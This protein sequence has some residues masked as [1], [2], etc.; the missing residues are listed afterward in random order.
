[1]NID[2]SNQS[3]SHHSKEYYSLK[4]K[5]ETTYSELDQ[6]IQSNQYNIRWLHDFLPSQSSFTEQFNKHDDDPFRLFHNERFYLNKEPINSIP[7]TNC[8][9]VILLCEKLTYL[10]EVL[11][12]LSHQSTYSHYH[13]FLSL[14]CDS[15]HDS[16]YIKSRKSYLLDAYK[17]SIKTLFNKRDSSCS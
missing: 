3:K 8:A 17:I 2:F 5:T 1:M 10:D 9:I 12:T 16:V 4:H 13:L 11:D 7:L 15:L 14:G 6:L